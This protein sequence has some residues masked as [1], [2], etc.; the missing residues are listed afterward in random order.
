LTAYTQQLFTED[1]V[2]DDVVSAL[3]AGKTQV[4]RR[5]EIYESDGVTPHK[6][7][8]N[9]RLVS[10]S[11]AVNQSSTARRTLDCV[12]D[13]SDGLLDHNPHGGFWYDKIIKVF[14][15]VRYVNLKFKP[16]IGT[17]G[18]SWGTNNRTVSKYLARLGIVDY[19]VVQLDVTQSIPGDVDILVA[20]SNTANFSAT[21]A[22]ILLASYQQGFNIL[23]VNNYATSATVPLIGTTQ[24]RANSTVWNVTPR[25]D[26]DIPFTDRLPKAFTATGVNGET[27]PT[28]VS[29]GSVYAATATDG[30]TTI[31]PVIFQRG[32][33]GARWVHY[34]PTMT[35]NIT[36]QSSY[37]RMMMLLG[38]IVDWLYSY[39][40]ERIWETQVGEFMLN[41]I[42]QP[43]FPA[44]ITIS[45]VDYSKKLD[46][47]K[48]SSPIAWEAGTD[49]DTIIKGLIIG[50]G[51][52]KY[53]INTNRNDTAIKHSYDRDTPITDILED[54]RKAYDFEWYFDRY[55]YFVAREPLDPT[56]SPISLELEGGI[57]GNLVDFDRQSDDSELRNKIT[58][59]GEDSKGNQ[60]FV[61][62]AENADPN[63]PASTKRIGIR[64]MTI[65][66]KT[67]TSTAGCKAHAQRELKRRGLE[68]YSVSFSAI[69]FPWL[70]G[71]EIIHSKKLAL[72]GYADRYL[73]TD[74]TVPLDLAPMDGN[75]KRLVIIVDQ[76]DTG[77]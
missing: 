5:V 22:Q 33:H 69:S 17:L 2:D 28:S 40:D 30:A 56:T 50:A 59:V 39:G 11:V 20:W 29:T 24:V 44:Q 41:N 73:M 23:T 35:D 4:T 26:R 75:G 15:G 65:V 77:N 52:T 14:R 7:G 3:L 62:T 64:S 16:K 6:A 9:P 66:S 25:T 8:K 46:L 71:G 34:H 10:G 36:P 42:S 74:F 27:E 57:G 31:Y 61:Y 60:A 51:V 19:E 43:R 18:F 1:D 63:N 12:L 72:D 13:N 38:G 47:D 68:A 21:I 32:A 49:I 76:N 45:G 54:L 70:E 58:V 37:S 67:I 55:G 53:R 48:L